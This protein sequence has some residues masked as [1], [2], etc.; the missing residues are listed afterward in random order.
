MRKTSPKYSWNKLQTLVCL[1]GEGQGT[2]DQHISVCPAKMSEWQEMSGEWPERTTQK[3]REW[4]RPK[5]LAMAPFLQVVGKAV[6]ACWQLFWKLCVRWVKMSECASKQ[7]G[8][9]TVLS[10]WPKCYHDLL[11]L[12]KGWHSVLATCKRYRKKTLPMT[13]L[14]FDTLLSTVSSLNSNFCTVNSMPL[15]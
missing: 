11:L 13:E 15:F 1:C 3:K 5:G 14:A 4:V 12:S 2:K 6:L 9:N 7:K 10:A 8:L